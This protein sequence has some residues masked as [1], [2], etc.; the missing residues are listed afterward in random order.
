MSPRA[1]TCSCAP[2]FR[3][4]LWVAHKSTRRAGHSLCTCVPHRLFLALGWNDKKMPAG[5][6]AEAWWREQRYS[7]F[8]EATDLPIITAHHL[9]DAV[10]NWIFT[11][12][13]GNPFLI[14]HKRGQ[15]LRPFLTT[16]KSKLE[17]WCNRKEVPYLTDPSNVDT[18]HRR[19]YIRHV[20]MPH[21]ENI[22]PGI[23]KTIKKK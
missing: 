2:I 15:Y 22:N 5:V 16:E 1:Y 23:K 17:S 20:M 7:F 3:C 11:S 9:G 12:L 6:S 14:P 4:V 10:E 8:E 13:N 18:K 21:V 19:N